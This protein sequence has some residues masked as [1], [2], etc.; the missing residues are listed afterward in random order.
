MA[1][2]FNS[3]S[4]PI[5]KPQGSPYCADPNCESCKE[6]REMQERIRSENV[7]PQISAKTAGPET[8]RLTSRD[9][10]AGNSVNYR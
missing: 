8:S 1:S 6:L 7:V 3:H 9:G 4:A 10:S 5:T 2:Q